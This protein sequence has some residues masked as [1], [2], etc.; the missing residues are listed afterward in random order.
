MILE[1]RDT[2]RDWRDSGI[3]RAVAVLYAREGADIAI[4]YLNEHEDAKP[5]ATMLI[6]RVAC[7]A[8]SLAS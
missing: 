6:P 3:G 2:G 7:S 8:V 5:S 1:G 4:V